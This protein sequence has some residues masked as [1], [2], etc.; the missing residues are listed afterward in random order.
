MSLISRF[1]PPVS[2]HLTRAS[3]TRA[4]LDAYRAQFF[5]LAASCFAEALRLDPTDGAAQ[6]NLAN[7][8]WS[9][10]ALDYAATIAE[11]AL[12][13]AHPTV[14]FEAWMINGAIR[15]ARGNALGAVNA[16]HAAVTCAPSAATA[17]AGLAAA[18]LQAGQSEA[19]SAQADVALTLN[20]AC[21]HA[22][23]SKAASLAAQADFTSAITAYD[24]IIAANPNDATAWLNR[25][26]AK[27][28][29]DLLSDAQAD[30]ATATRLDPSSLE[31]WVTRGYA[32]CLA[33]NLTEAIAHA[34]QAISLN[35]EHP[36][37]HWNRGIA[38]LL[39][40]DYHSGFAAYEWRKRH[41]I[42]GKSFTTLPAPLW[43]GEINPCENSMGKHLLI[44]AEQGMGDTIMLARF[45]PELAARGLRIT[46]ACAPSLHRLLSAL[47]A[48]LI[49][50]TTPPPDLHFDY[51]IDQMS[52]PLALH[53]TRESIP[54]PAAYLTA[55]P[56]LQASAQSW[57]AQHTNSSK[58]K[59]GFVWAGNPEH[60]N[61]R[62]RSLPPGI[63]KPLLAN[64][65]FTAIA[66]QHGPRRGEY[67]LPDAITQVHDYADTAALISTLDAVVTVDTSVAHLAGALGV[68]CHILLSTAC[69]WRWG[70]IGCES[71]WYPS[72]RLH[73]QAQ[74]GDWQAPLRS[75]TAAL[76]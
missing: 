66:L 40:G 56:D 48:N 34:E 6:I 21:T 41:K 8:L 68:P 52:L 22:Q 27:L 37:P 31:A 43:Q 15:L 13:Q 54:A 42:H 71:L 25:A 28:D 50:L 19:A 1:D 26:A 33:G 69:D 45:I 20:P 12:A 3:L 38:L 32:A 74:L 62:R 23:A 14:Q 30:L 70:L 76:R 55:N 65:H 24:Q 9:L 17:H 60:D 75:L 2:S 35:P 59:I 72:V 16:Y 44:R 36:Q 73:R 63:L 51:A 4:G 29:L 46:L 64:P 61:D 47:P 11:A 39:L 67:S 10:G 49:N 53:L 7:A 18:L 58:R 5:A 57:L